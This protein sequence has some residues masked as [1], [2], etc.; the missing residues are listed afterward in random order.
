MCYIGTFCS[1][2]DDHIR[3]SALFLDPIYQFNRGKLFQFSASDW[4]HW[5]ETAFHQTEP[6]RKLRTDA[7][8]AHVFIRKQMEKQVAP[9]NAHV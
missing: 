8:L 9:Q 4:R 1:C 5:P 2:G 3:S 6:N 7:V